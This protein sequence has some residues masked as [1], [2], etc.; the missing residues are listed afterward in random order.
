MSFNKLILKIEYQLT[1]KTI[2][3]SPA[4]N[5]HSHEES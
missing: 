3:N 2:P 1:D 4:I 5:H